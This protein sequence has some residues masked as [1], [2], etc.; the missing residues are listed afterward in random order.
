MENNQ[1][2]TPEEHTLSDAL[3]VLAEAPADTVTL[4]PAVFYGLSDLPLSDTPQFR[5]AWQGLPAELRS[6]AARLLVETSESNFEFQY[7]TVALVL[8]EDPEAEVRKAAVELLW[9]SNRLSVLDELL[10]VL[11]NE[12]NEVVRAEIM[13]VLGQF[14]LE[15]EYEEIPASAAKRAQDAAIAAQNA[16]SEPMLV[17]RRALEAI[18]NCSRDGVREMIRAAYDSKNHD[19][20]VSAV[21]AMGR[22]YDRHWTAIVMEEL[23]S[24]DPEMQ[25]EAVRASGQLELEETLPAIARFSMQSDDRE[26]QEVSIWALG[27]IGGDEAT[28]YL[29]QLAD[30]MEDAEG[31]GELQAAIEDAI[32]NAQLR[33]DF[34][35]LADE[36]GE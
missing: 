14:I 8:L 5:S 12:P 20:R 9:E 35:A 24:K 16:D 26:L 13:N 25:Y 19:M 15:G 4:P 31:E 29:S 33:L 1:F 2:E 30:A 27:E 34:D 32:H 28:N 7:E 18:S 11:S 6:R 17:R 22:T 10:N 21:H 3:A 23:A 36:W